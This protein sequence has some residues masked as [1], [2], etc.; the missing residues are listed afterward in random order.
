MP[1]PLPPPPHYSPFKAGEFRWS[2]G[3]EPPDLHEWI[4]V[5]DHSPLQLAERSGCSA[6][7]TTQSSTPCQSRKRAQRRFWNC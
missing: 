7:G 6:S 5:D 2:M 1:D 4:E 3:L